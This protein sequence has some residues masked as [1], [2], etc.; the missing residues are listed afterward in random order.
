[1]SQKIKKYDPLADV[2]NLIDGDQI[3]EE[4]I[5]AQRL[6]REHRWILIATIVVAAAVV[7]ASINTRD[8]LRDARL[9]ECSHFVH[10]QTG[11]LDRETT[12]TSR[13]VTQNPPVPDRMRAGYERGWTSG[14]PASYW[15][16]RYVACMGDQI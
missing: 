5:V 15:A 16:D 10:A 2:E 6:R 14:I 9:A 12:G 7:F 1:M 8:D 13:L 11:A 3:D 4:L